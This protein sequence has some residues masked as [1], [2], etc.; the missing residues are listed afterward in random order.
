MHQQPWAAFQ[1]ALSMRLQ[2]KL[3]SNTL[4]ITVQSQKILNA[5]NKNEHSHNLVSVTQKAS[6]CHLYHISQ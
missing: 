6:D 1:V 5:Q 4:K 2:R 3:H